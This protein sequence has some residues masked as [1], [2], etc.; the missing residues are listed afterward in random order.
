MPLSPL[1]GPPRLEGGAFYLGT[2]ELEDSIQATIQ[3]Y[4]D[5]LGLDR[6][7]LILS[8]LSMGTFPALYYGAYFEPKGL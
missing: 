6:S 8:G 1:F 5:Y 4:L 3:H 2:G 7:D